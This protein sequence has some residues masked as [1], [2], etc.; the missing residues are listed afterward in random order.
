MRHIPC[1]NTSSTTQSYLVMDD[2]FVYGMSLIEDTLVTNTTFTSHPDGADLSGRCTRYA[3]DTDQYSNYM[4]SFTLLNSQSI[5]ACCCQ[6]H[7]AFD[8]TVTHACLM[9]SCSWLHCE[10]QTCCLF[11]DLL[12]VQVM[13]QPSE[14]SGQS[15]LTAKLTW[16]SHYL[17]TQQGSK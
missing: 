13:R 12:C 1:R 11:V 15:S 3:Q 6:L 7:A 10:T 16:S 17:H 8:L 5:A 14:L 9:L 4:S 2:V